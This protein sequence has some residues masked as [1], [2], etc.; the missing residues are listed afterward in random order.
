MWIP[1]PCL[2]RW[3]LSRL[4]QAQRARN[5]SGILAI[6][7]SEA[8]QEVALQFW[9]GKWNYSVQ[10]PVWYSQ[11]WLGRQTQLNLT[12]WGGGRVRAELSPYGS[13]PGVT[14]P[15]QRGSWLADLL[16]AGPQC[17]FVCRPGLSVSLGRHLVLISPSLSAPGPSVPHGLPWQSCFWCFFRVEDLSCSC[18]YF[19]VL[20]GIS[21]PGKCTWGPG[22]AGVSWLSV[23]ALTPE[24][25]SHRH[26]GWPPP[27]N[28]GKATSRSRLQPL[29]PF[30]PS[31]LPLVM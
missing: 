12:C 16:A 7:K 24:E 30:P 28:E 9:P 20:W 10:L 18:I 8:S 1:E 5:R 31:S 11:V 2:A 17:L 29:P 25:C 15:G 13:H 22:G 3:R 4:E 27:P 6:P 21:T 14:K 23:T 26:P 19:A